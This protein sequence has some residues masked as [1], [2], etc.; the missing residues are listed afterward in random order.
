MTQGSLLCTL[1]TSGGLGLS[2]SGRSIPFQK[3]SHESLEVRF[4]YF[5]GSDANKVSDI[6]LRWDHS[7]DFLQFWITLITSLCFTIN[8]CEY[9]QYFIRDSKTLKW[10]FFR[11]TFWMSYIVLEF[12]LWDFLA[13]FQEVS[14][15]NILRK[16]SILLLTQS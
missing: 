9:C 8:Y 5:L 4:W 14:I 15:Q 16:Q 11:D 10:L 2:S 6:R 1:R 12:Y 3:Q 13:H 7:L